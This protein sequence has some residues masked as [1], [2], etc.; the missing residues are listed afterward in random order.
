MK[1]KN[2]LD[3]I[4]EPFRKNMDT[5][6]SAMHDTIPKVAPKQ[7]TSDALFLF[8]IMLIFYSE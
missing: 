6:S 3:D 7:N 1:T 5:A 8:L 4:P 2:C